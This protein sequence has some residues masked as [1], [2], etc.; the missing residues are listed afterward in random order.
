MEF[1]L[2]ADSKVKKNDSAKKVWHSP[3]A[4][5][6]DEIRM[7]GPIQ[8][9]SIVDGEGLRAV[10][11]TQG[12]WRKCPGCHNPET[13]DFEDGSVIKIEDV[14]EQLR[15]F[16]GQSGITFSG[17]EPMMQ[18]KA[19]LEIARFAREEMGWN[20]WSFSGYTYEQLREEGGEKWDLV[21]ELDVLIDG[22]FIQAEKDLTLRFRG[23]ANQR[24]IRLK[25]GEILGIE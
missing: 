25:D 11:W 18:P 17:G 3:G 21:R 24:L 23:S 14:K 10:L 8:S 15:K 2:M 7:S 9:D 12:C 5:A 16:K 1:G 22:P 20:V 6:D 4:V 13:W 19:L